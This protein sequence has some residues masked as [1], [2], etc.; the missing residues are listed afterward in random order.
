MSQLFDGFELRRGVGDG[1]AIDGF[2]EIVGGSDDAVSGSDGG[3]RCRM[4]MICDSVC[5][6]DGTC[7]FHCNFDAS[8]VIQCGSDVPSGAGMRCPC[9]AIAWFLM[10]EC[11]SSRRCH[12]CGI[13]IV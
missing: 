7:A 12:W 9:V 6:S 1:L 10:D 8:V 5:H 3:H 11:V 2:G 4:M 13:K